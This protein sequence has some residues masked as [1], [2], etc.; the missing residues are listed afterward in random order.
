M[1]SSVVVPAVTQTEAPLSSLA[2]LTPSDFG[3]M[4]P[5]PS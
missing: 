3:T 4:K 5:W 1:F 2:E